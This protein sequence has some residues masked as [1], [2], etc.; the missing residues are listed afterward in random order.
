MQNK[1]CSLL[2]AL[3]CLQLRHIFK[4]LV[5]AIFTA[6]SKHLKDIRDI[7]AIDAI[8]AAICKTAAAE[9]LE[10]KSTY[11][12]PQIVSGNSKKVFHRE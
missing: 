5:I 7:Y 2:M 9:A 1:G 11:L 8:K 10:E 6:N 4:N 3:I 12:T